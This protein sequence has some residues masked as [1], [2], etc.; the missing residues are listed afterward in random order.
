VCLYRLAG[1]LGWAEAVFLEARCYQ[2]AVGV[3][4]DHKE[5]L[6][7]YRR[8]R[9]LGNSSARSFLLSDVDGLVAAEEE[10]RIKRRAARAYFVQAAEL[11]SAE[12]MNAAGEAFEAEGEEADIQEALR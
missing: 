6:D 9:A 12:A 8:S 4:R 1:L 5:A 11:G 3:R 10:L 2:L 7:L